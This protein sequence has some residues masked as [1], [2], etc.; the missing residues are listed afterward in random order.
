MHFHCNNRL[1]DCLNSS[2]LNTLWIVDE[3]TSSAV[4]AQVRPCDSLRAITHR[5]DIYQQLVDNGFEVSLNDYEFETFTAAEFQHIVFPVA[6]ERALANHCINWAFRLLALQGKLTLLGEKNQ[7]IKTHFK[8][9]ETVF[10]STGIIKKHGNCYVAELKKNSAKGGAELDSKHYGDLRRVDIDE[11]SF[12]SKP[13]IFG[14][15]KVDQGSALLVDQLRQLLDGGF[16]AAGSLLDLGCGYGYLL[17]MTKD[18]PF[19]HRVATDN[20][21]AAVKAAL[22]NCRENQ[23]EVDVTLDSAGSQLRETFDLILCNPPFHRGFAVDGDLTT[24]F[25]TQ[26]R[27]LLAPQG[28]ALMVVNQFIPL[29][30]IAMSYFNNID[31]LFQEQGFKVVKLS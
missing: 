5:F 29:E 28:T 8:N 25:L 17:L 20:N 24:L 21:A 12:L 3:T 30:K 6:K 10:T 23:L 2:A 27:R 13:G 31:V 9:A 19:N 16:K 11:F 15:D 7:G 1:V 26:C 18:L 22:A 4:Q 14:W